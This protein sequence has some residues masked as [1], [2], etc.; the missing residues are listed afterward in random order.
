MLNVIIQG[1][2]KDFSRVV[3]FQG[4]FK[5][6]SVFQGLFKIR[7]NPALNIRGPNYSEWRM[8][9]S[10]CP[11]TKSHDWGSGQFGFSFGSRAKK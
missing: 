2:F 5:S 11:K 3:H 1:L 8:K 4:L 6:G 9:T 10:Q 7:T